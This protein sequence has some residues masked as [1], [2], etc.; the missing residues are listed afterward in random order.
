ML[1]RSDV[2][3][4]RSVG[5]ARVAKQRSFGY[6]LLVSSCP[7]HFRNLRQPGKDRSAL[8]PSLVFDGRVA[9]DDMARR[10]IVGN[11]GLRSRQRTVANPAMTGH[12]HLARKNNPISYGG[13]TCQAD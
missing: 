9:T 6:S 13:R 2:R 3:E 8:E 5:C 1:P 11:S 4:A 12:S 10:Y 7:Y